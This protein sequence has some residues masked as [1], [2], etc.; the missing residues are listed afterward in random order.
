MS[1]GPARALALAF[2]LLAPGCALTDPRPVIVAMAPAAARERTLVI[3][4]DRDLANLPIVEELAR[5]FAF[6]LAQRGRVVADLAAF[7]EATQAAGRV[8]PEPV[9]LRLQA[10]LVDPEGVAWLR[11]GEVRHVIVLEV[12]LYDQV[13][14]PGGEGKRTRVGLIA[15]G[16]DL[17]RDDPAW[18]AHSTP[19][20]Q[21]EPGQG[22]QIG[23]EAALAAL[24][25]VVSG[26][27]EPLLIPK[28][29]IPYMPPLKVPW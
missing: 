28:I 23:T 13:W 22:F 24:V 17:V 26:E 12:K 18:Y 21:D 7:V 15:R 16:R 11:A 29:S 19:E 2:A 14:A 20:V 6:G 10:G 1:A 9:R 27:A 3:G 4:S 25:R 8:V 5:R